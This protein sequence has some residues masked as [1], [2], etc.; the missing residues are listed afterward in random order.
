MSVKLRVTKIVCPSCSGTGK[1]SNTLAINCMW[2]HGETRVPVETAHRYANQ[3]WILTS[4]GFIAGD[5]D[6]EHKVQMEGHA[7]QV[8]A[9]TG[10]R[11]PWLV[12]QD[13][14]HEPR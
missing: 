5:H 4:G 11:A 14:G 2:C 1:F 13:P 9:L 8:Y 6:F 10:H 7:E 3:L 12:K